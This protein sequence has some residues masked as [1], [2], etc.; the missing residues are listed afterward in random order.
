MMSIKRIAK[1]IV[2]SFF[3]LG[4]TLLVC[5]MLYRNNFGTH[6]INIIMCLALFTIAVIT[7][8]YIYGVFSAIIAVFTYDFVITSPRF[9]FSFTVGFPITLII[10]IAV[11]LV[12][13]AI[14]NRMKIKLNTNRDKCELAEMLYSINSKLLSTREVKT[15]ARY[16]LEY[17]KDELKHSVAF[18]EEVPLNGKL[19]PYFRQGKDDVNID[20]FM[21]EKVIDCVRQVLNS[22]QPLDANGFGFFYPVAIQNHMYGVFAFSCGENAFTHKKKVYLSLIASQTAQALRIY[23]LMLEQQE[24][25]VSTET[26]KVKNSLLRSISHDLRT[27]LTGIIG[28]SGTLLENME[29]LPKE[30]QIKLIQGIQRDSQWLLNMIENILSITKVQGNNMK[31]EKTDELVEE[32]VEEAVINFRKYFPEA[33]VTVKQSNH[34]VWVPM[35]IMLI[36]Q[37]LTNLLEN[38]QRHAQNHKSDVIVEVKEY[39]EHVCFVV[40]DNGP[41]IE[42]HVL[43]HLFQ[44]SDSL[45]NPYNDSSKG[46]GIGLSICKTI[47]NAH[48]GEIKAANLLQGGAQFTFTLPC[49]ERGL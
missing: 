46:W 39:E 6:N 2:I 44:F 32:A 16:S 7:D 23:R 33:K 4:I 22:H 20:Y 47:V 8:G 29:E 13:S 41:G 9:G 11:V 18:Y 17:L 5:E 30:V 42:E 38:T 1:N 19:T 25:S 48:G 34:A 26:E 40:Q 43:E 14:T 10:M 12:S 27:P 21:Q 37:V 31:I 36:S 28:S 15:I 24:A 49:A 35:D 3:I 45:D